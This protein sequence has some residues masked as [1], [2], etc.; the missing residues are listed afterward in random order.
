MRDALAFLFGMKAKKKA[1]HFSNI[2]KS[3]HL[4]RFSSLDVCQVFFASHSV[5]FVCFF[6]DKT[7]RYESFSAQNLP[8]CISH[9]S[10]S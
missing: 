1:A 7:K 6:S 10:S 9:G 3:A 4:M 5:F 2:E 8:P